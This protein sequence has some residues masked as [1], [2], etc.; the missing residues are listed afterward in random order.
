MATKHEQR[1]SEMIGFVRARMSLAVIWSNTPLLRG[2]RVGRAFRPEILDGAVIS[3][4][5]GVQEW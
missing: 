4:M 5:E 3:A 2:A 1:Y